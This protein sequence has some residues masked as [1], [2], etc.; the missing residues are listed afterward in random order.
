M[1]AWPFSL[2]IN[3]NFSPHYGIAQGF[4]ENPGQA[5]VRAWSTGKRPALK[6]PPAP[7][8]GLGADKPIVVLERAFLA[9]GYPLNRSSTAWS[10]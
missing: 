9:A 2:L 7:R 4:V 6:R 3:R 8:I 5:P 10:S 1:G